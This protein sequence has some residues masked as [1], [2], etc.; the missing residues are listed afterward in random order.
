MLSIRE[1]RKLG[2]SLSAERFARELGPFVIIQKP[3]KLQSPTGTQLMGV[4]EAAL[5]T[6]MARPEKLT[7]DV[8]SLLFQFEDLQV[9]TLPPVE[10]SAE[11]TVGRA[12]DCDVVLDDPS[13]SKHHAVLRWNAQKKV[14]ILEDLGSTNGSYLNAAIRVRKA[15]LLRDGD[16]ISFGEVPF[17]YLLTATLFERLKTGGS[18]AVKQS[19]HRG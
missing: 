17:W 5:G 10:G 14:C 18:G 19:P 13:V 8:L 7:S 6:Q 2:T 16:I 4:P 12:P 9:A 15:V 11:I 3:E 1:I